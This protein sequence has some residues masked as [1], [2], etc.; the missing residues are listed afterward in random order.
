VQGDLQGAV[1][2]V[3]HGDLRV[4]SGVG[5]TW[6]VSQGLTRAGSWFRS[7]GRGQCPQVGYGCGSV[8]WA[9]RC[10]RAVLLHIS[11]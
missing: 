2:G 8:S 11:H 9:A 3:V 6:A 1:Q 4:N 7:V 5:V 10:R